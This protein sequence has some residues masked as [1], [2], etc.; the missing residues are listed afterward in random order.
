MITTEKKIGVPPT[1]GRATISVV[2][3]L[4]SCHRNAALIG[5]RIFQHDNGLVYQDANHMAMPDSDM[6]FDEMLKRCIRMNAMSTESGNVN[7][8]TNTLRTCV[9]MSKIQS[10]Q[11]EA[12]VENLLHRV[13]RVSISRVRH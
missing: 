3:P 13:N 2:S 5:G 12:H 9:R 10:W 8:T 4:S 11:T 6:M 7:T 1:A